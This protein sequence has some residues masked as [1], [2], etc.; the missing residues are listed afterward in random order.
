LEKFLPASLGEFLPASAGND[1]LTK[2]SKRNGEINRF[3]DVTPKLVLSGK[4]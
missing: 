1:K 2:K 3:I 4:S